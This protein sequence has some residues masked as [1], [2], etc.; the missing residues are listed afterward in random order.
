MILAFH[1]IGKY[2]RPL[3]AENDLSSK[4]IKNIISFFHRQGYTF[5]PIKEY[6]SGHRYKTAVITFDDGY[7][8]Q[9]NTS[10]EIFARYNIKACFFISTSKIGEM[11]KSVDGMLINGISSTQIKSLYE[12]GHTIGSHGHSHEIQQDSNFFSEDLKES[13]KVLVS[14]TGK[15]PEYYSAP[16]GVINKNQYAILKETMK[17]SFSLGRIGMICCRNEPDFLMNRIPVNNRDTFLRLRF[18]KILFNI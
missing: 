9:F 15:K 5:V 11:W 7:Y 3:P 17:Y 2:S 4:K 6:L 14:I 16:F 10:V 12:S 13:I 1:N 8:D 18:K